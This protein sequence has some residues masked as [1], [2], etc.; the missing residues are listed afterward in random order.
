MNLPLTEREQSPRRTTNKLNNPKTALVLMGT[1]LAATA[2][3]FGQVR[4]GWFNIPNNVNISEANFAP[5]HSHSAVTV[6]D[7][8]LNNIGGGGWTGHYH[9]GGWDSSFNEDKYITFTVSPNNGRNDFDRMVITVATLGSWQSSFVVRSSADGFASNLGATSLGN[10]QHCCHSFNWTVDLS[11]MPIQYG[12]TEFRIYAYDGGTAGWAGTG[13]NSTNAGCQI[14]G[15]TLEPDSDGDGVGDS[16]DICAGFDDA[17]DT[18]SDGEPDGCDHCPLFDNSID[19]NGNGIADGCDLDN[20]T[21]TEDFEGPNVA[22]VVTGFAG[23]QNGYMRLTQAT[24]AQRGNAIFYPL[25]NNPVASF[26]ASFD[27]KMGGGEGADGMCFSL[28]DDNLHTIWTTFGE[29]GPGAGSLTISLDT[30]GTTAEDGNHAILRYNDVILASEL[31]NFT[32][33]NREWNHAEITFDGATLTLVLTPFDGPTETP[34]LN[35]PVPGFVPTPALFGVGARTGGFTN[36]HHVDNLSFTDTSNHNDNNFNG[37]PDQCDPD[38]D[39]DGVID[40]QD[41]CEGFD[42]NGLD[43]NGNGIADACDLV[44]RARFENFADADPSFTLNREAAH[45]SGSIRLTAAAPG[46]WGSVIFEPVS[47]DPVGSFMVSFDFKMGGGS[48]ADGMGF[49]VLD[50]NAY[51]QTTHLDER[52]PGPDSLS[53]GFDTYAG[54]Q[55]GGNHAQLRLGDTMLASY[56]VDFTLNDNKWHH[57]DIIFDGA[58]L[59]MVLTPNGGAPQET[60]FSNV[61]VPGFTPTE[62]LYGFGARTGAAHDEHRVDNVLFIDTSNTNDCDGNN[63]P[64]QCDPDTDNDGWIDGCDNCP[65]IDN[66]AQ[67]DADDDGVGDACDICDGFD[68][69]VDTDGDGT[70]DGCDDCNRLLGDVSGDLIVDMDDMID[71]VAILL[72]PSQ[73]TADEYCAADANGDATVDGRD[74]QAFMEL[75]LAP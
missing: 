57:A 64:D 54:N 22:Y 36:Y 16:V 61:A 74:V 7:M 10:G 62:I 25:T 33:D 14:W 47:L 28:L 18:D 19:C 8:T 26:T 45:E 3:A 34:L 44:D 11:D 72:D 75:L 65:N 69:Q 38:T 29:S 63:V 15:T 20:P 17:I 52:G 5:T 49:A 60:A 27:F 66:A 73:A 51:D 40:G 55:A 42:D 4:L 46:Q 32:L 30:F 67:S 41:V 43:C 1:L 58:N 56:L 37:I 21:W 13:I 6:S 48:G 24:F 2:P 68:D 23:P 70:P 35:V 59:T 71:F 31:V 9:T 39:G 53:I 50:A 12:A